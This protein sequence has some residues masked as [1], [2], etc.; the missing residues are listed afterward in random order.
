MT[1][2]LNY[3]IHTMYAKRLPY[4]VKFP[5]H[6]NFATVAILNKLLQKKVPWK[7]SDVIQKII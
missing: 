5:G 1:I 4:Y 2:A 3:L 6:F 7:L